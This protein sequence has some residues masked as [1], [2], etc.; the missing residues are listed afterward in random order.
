MQRTRRIASANISKNQEE[1]VMNPGARIVYCFGSTKYKSAAF[2]SIPIK[3]PIFAD[4]F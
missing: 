3:I 1:P 4:D 2:L